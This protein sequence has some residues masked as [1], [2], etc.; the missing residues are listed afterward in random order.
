MSGPAVVELRP[1]PCAITRG[2]RKWVC[3]SRVPGSQIPRA[4]AHSLAGSTRAPT[5]EHQRPVCGRVTPACPSGGG[6]APAPSR[7]WRCARRSCA[8]CRTA[9]LPRATR[10]LDLGAT[11]LEVQRQRHERVALLGDLALDLGDLGAVQQQLALAARGVVGPGALGVLRDV[12]V[13]QPRLAVV[14]LGEAVDQRGAPLRAATS[15]RCRPAPGRPRRCRRCGSRGAPS[16]SARR[17]CAPAPW[18]SGHS[19]RQRAT[20]FRTGG[21]EPV[22]RVARAGR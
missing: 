7:G 16:C 2:G 4:A 10:D 3:R 5:P 11:V 22:H 6:R 1:A 19:L 13:V 8:A 18:P 9:F 15:P 12:D 17:S 21:S 20:R 14:D